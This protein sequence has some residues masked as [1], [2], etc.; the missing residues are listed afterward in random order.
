MSF[1]FIQHYD[2]DEMLANVMT[3]DKASAVLIFVCDQ[4]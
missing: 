3:A 2:F 4:F 1:D